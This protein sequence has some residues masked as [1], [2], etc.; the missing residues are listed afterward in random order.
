RTSLSRAESG[1]TA[2][3]SL[4]TSIYRPTLLFLADF[5]GGVPTRLSF[6][7]VPYKDRAFICLFSA[8]CLNT[9]G[10]PGPSTLTEL[11]HMDVFLCTKEKDGSTASL[12][13]A[14]RLKDPAIKQKSCLTP[15]SP[16]AL[17]PLCSTRC[18]CKLS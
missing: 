15:H 3:V 8:G 14:D 10:F 11:C 5:E 17:V 6:R 13:G 2:N 18:S 7:P 12:Y 9:E 16:F 4:M 1:S